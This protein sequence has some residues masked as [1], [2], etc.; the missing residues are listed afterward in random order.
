MAR[1]I[2]DPAH[3]EVSFKVKHLM[4]TNVKGTFKKSTADVVTTD[5]DFSPVEV[6]AKVDADSADTGDEKRDAHLKSPDFFYVEEYPYLTFKAT[7]FVKKEGTIYEMYGD[8]TIRDITKEIMLKTEFGGFMKDP[9]GQTKAG[10]SV[11]G[12]INR[13]D[14]NLNW[15]AALEA[16]GVL[17]SDEVRISCEVQLL[18]MAEGT[19]ASSENAA[20]AQ[21]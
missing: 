16:G 13:K 17:V 21:N 8:L 15:N 5:D 1:W 3:S 18:R 2:L 6:L 9:W 11:E 10:F 20:V 14:W 19:N 4:I 7:R 12:K